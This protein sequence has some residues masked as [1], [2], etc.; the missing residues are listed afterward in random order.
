MTL[1][2][3]FLPTPALIAWTALSLA[4]LRADAHGD[5]G[6]K[7]LKVLDPALHK[8]LDDGMKSLAK[9]LGVECTACHVRGHFERDDVPAKEI[10]RKFF[11]VAV[12]EED[13]VKRTEA[14]KPV[15]EALHRKA[16]K[17][18]SKIWSA[19]GRW[20]KQSS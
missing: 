8:E 16:P 12:G 18:E 19:I 13:A 20:K 1:R 2:P 17:D 11:S 7:N 10:A 3:R 15:L 6:H 5:H 9:G 14:L 4:S